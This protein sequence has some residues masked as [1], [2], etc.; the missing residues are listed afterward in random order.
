MIIEEADFRLIPVGTD[1]WDLDLS[2]VINKG[3][4]N[5]RIEFDNAGYGMTL[6]KCF[7]KIMRNRM[8]NKFPEGSISLAAFLKEYKIIESELKELCKI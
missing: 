3:K 8:D 7:K 4:P 6:E 5:E 2:K 1:L